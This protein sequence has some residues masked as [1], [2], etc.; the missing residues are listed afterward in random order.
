MKK[1]VYIVEQSS[2]IKAENSNLIIKRKGASI[3][4][5]PLMNVKRLYIKGS[6]V[7][8]THLLNEL[9][10]NKIDIIFLTFNGNFRSKIPSQLGKNIDLRRA[11]YRLFENEKLRNI[12]ASKFVAGKVWNSYIIA[13]RNKTLNESDKLNAMLSIYEQLKTG[14]FTNDVLMGK[15]GIV[16]KHY[17]SIF[18]QQ[19]KNEDFVFNGRNR[20]PPKDPINAMLSLGYSFLLNEVLLLVERT[21]LDPYLGFLH[22][23]DYGRPS[24][25]LDIIEE[26]RSVIVDLLVISMINKR[27]VGLDDF[28]EIEFRGKK[29]VYFDGDKIKSFI[30]HFNHRME[31]KRFYEKRGFEMSY[32]EILKSKVYD[33]IEFIKNQKE[34]EPF[35]LRR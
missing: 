2:F 23:P 3:V 1:D 6:S 33:L 26:F 22:L 12:I 18:A 20:R 5:V 10:D 9:L 24:L 31:T 14:Q 13:K 29:G 16:S 8:S 11:Q 32:K 21:G 4:R 35:R 19:I 15:E 25:A 17:F 7:I 30:Y 34:Y 27:I 28:K